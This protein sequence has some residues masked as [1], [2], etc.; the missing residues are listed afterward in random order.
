[1]G[2][3]HI[4][5]L[6]LAILTAVICLSGCS[7]IKK[8]QDLKVTSASITRIAP[9]GLNGINLE[10]KLEIDNPGTQ[11]SLSEISCDV[12][13]FGKV[14]GKVAV[15]PFTINQK[16][17]D[18]YNLRADVRLGDGV[19]LLEA[20][21]LLRSMSPDNVTLD[22]KAKVKLKGGVSKKLT[23]NDIPLKKLIET[24]RQ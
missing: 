8:L 12:K 24:A 17:H 10:A 19:S 9:N 15:D 4:S 6:V 14:L 2:K 5:S 7:G 11:I 23:Y 16:T 18:L 20:G 1:M 22:L 3:N 13:H 21:R